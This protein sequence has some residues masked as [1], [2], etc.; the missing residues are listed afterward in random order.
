MR[1]LRWKNFIAPGL[2]YLAILSLSLLPKSKVDAVNDLIPL[3]NDKVLH[4][5]V[6]AGL[7]FLLGGLP[8]PSPVLGMAGSGLGALDEQ[9]QRWAPGREVCV[10]D[11][12]ADMIGISLGLTLRRG[13]RR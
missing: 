11:W 8:Y 7:G 6:Y 2:Y 13:L 5:G 3:P 12:I 10:P 9:I 1:K 4:I